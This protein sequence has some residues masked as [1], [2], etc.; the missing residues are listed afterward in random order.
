MS[1]KHYIEIASAFKREVTASDAAHDTHA[2]MALE[3][4][5]HDLCRMF[6]ADNTQFNRRRFL[7]ACG[8]DPDYTRHTEVTS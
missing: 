2:V 8:F 1:R 4:V 3:R 5:A 7:D 6:K